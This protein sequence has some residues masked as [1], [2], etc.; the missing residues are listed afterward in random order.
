[1]GT[2]GPGLAIVMD[3]VAAAAAVAQALLTRAHLHGY[4]GMG[5]EEGGVTVCS[6]MYQ[7]QEIQLWFYAVHR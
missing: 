2:V 5:V 3:C 1:M 4:K 6:S 7:Q